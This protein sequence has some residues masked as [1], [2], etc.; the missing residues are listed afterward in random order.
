MGAFQTINWYIVYIFCIYIVYV[1]DDKDIDNNN[2]LI[3]LDMPTNMVSQPQ[4]SICKR[5]NLIN[6]TNKGFFSRHEEI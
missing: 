6:C 5:R 2:D 1:N 4:L 3:H